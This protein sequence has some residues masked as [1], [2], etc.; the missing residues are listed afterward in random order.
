MR[1]EPSPRPNLQ[2]V[3]L[4]RT[5]VFKEIDVVPVVSTVLTGEHLSA[6]AKTL[7]VEST[8][9]F[10]K[11]GQLL[12]AGNHS[13]AQPE[14]VSYTGK[15]E[16]SFLNCKRGEE[17]TKAAAHWSGG[18]VWSL[19]TMQFTDKLPDAARQYYYT[20]RAREHSG[21]MS[22]YSRISNPAVTTTKR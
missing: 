9:G 2:G 1:S 19:S 13:M 21:L 5:G 3:K 17:K 7:T 8:E 4:D 16:T 11:H 10:P 14:V 18:R 20:I 15:T 6:M 12:I 22:P